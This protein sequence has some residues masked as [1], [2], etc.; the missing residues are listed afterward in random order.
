MDAHAKGSVSYSH[1]STIL[2]DR[3]G[4]ETRLADGLIEVIGPDNRRSEQIR[5][6]TLCACN[7][8]AKQAVDTA[9]SAFF[10]C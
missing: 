3:S 1:A 7:E 5:S 10:E 6:E 8:Q 9:V 2:M 4:S